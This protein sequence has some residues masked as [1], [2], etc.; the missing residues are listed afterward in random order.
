M[1]NSGAIYS[2]ELKQ[3]SDFLLKGMKSGGFLKTC[4][5]YAA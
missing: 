4:R 2:V 1:L 5:R 3:L